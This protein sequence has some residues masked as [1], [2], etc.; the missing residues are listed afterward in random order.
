MP[1]SGSRALAFRPA[2]DASA[3]DTLAACFD[4]LIEPPENE[5]VGGLAC[6]ADCPDGKNVLIDAS[7][8]RTAE[9]L[10]EKG[11]TVTRLDVSEFLKAGG[12]VFCMKL[13]LP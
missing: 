10:E 7:C 2:F 4:E 3:A 9:L 13:A 1:L 5:A 11:F 12:S 8:S 6:N